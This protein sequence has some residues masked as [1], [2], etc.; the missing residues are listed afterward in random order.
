MLPTQYLG[1][2]TA[3]STC[4]SP[5][6]RAHPVPGVPEQ[7]VDWPASE[8]DGFVFSTQNT[9]VNA[10]AYAAY[11]GDGPDRRRALG[12]PLARAP[13]PRSP[14]GIKAAMQAKLYD[15]ATGAF[16]DGVGIATRPSSRASTRWRSAWPAPP[17]AKTAAAWHRRPRHGL[18]RLLRGLPARGALRRRPAA[19]RAQPADRRHEHQLAAHDRPRRGLHHGGVDP[20]A[21]VQPQLLPPVGRLTR[22]HRARSTCSACR[23]SPPAG[24]RC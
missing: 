16:R 9:V 18:Q 3:W 10:F 23:R 12:D 15:P 11:C 1:P 24:A 13:T 20:R 17:Q 4:R 6:R 8:R 7:L 19:G 21:Q 2:P 22:V 5:V 14:R